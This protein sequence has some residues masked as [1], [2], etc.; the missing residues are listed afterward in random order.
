MYGTSDRNIKKWR[1]GDFEIKRC[2]V[3]KHDK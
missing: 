1:I 2:K 3:A